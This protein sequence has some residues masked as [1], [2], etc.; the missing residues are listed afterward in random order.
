MK[1]R[2]FTLLFVLIAS[3][4]AQTF[5]GLKAVLSE[6]E[7]KRAGLDKLTPDEIGVIDAALIRQQAGVTKQLQ[8]EVAAARTAAT[9]AP[10][11]ATAAAP[12]AMQR[13]G[14]PVFNDGDWRSLPPL[15]AKVVKWEGGNRFR[16][17]N[18]QVWE[19]HDQITY[20]LPGKEIEIHARPH[21][22]FALF[23]DGQN[24]TLR[25]MRLR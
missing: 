15:R 1:S 2:L 11:A 5:P 8:G 17:D 20:E 16:L 3:A 12:G 22:Q 25:V 4:S 19:G 23:V 9:S 21:G 14:L 10:V 13:F 6:A 24:T 18:G 7:W